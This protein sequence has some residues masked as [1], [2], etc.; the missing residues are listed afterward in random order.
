M[1]ILSSDPT[2]QLA[3]STFENKGVYALLLGS[4]LSRTAGIPTGWKITLD[5]VRRVALAQGVENQADWA[6]WYRK[7]YSAEPDYLSSDVRI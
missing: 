2:T 3:F 5:L 6:T 7:K 1:S 4:G